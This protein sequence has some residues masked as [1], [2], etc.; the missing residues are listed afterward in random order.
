MNTRNEITSS[1]DLIEQ[2]KEARVYSVGGLA[3]SGAIPIHQ[4][5]M[6]DGTPGTTIVDTGSGTTLNA[7]T[8]SG[9]SSVAGIT[10][11]GSDLAVDFTGSSSKADT[12]TGSGEFQ[13]NSLFSVAVWVNADNLSA[14]QYVFALGTGSTHTSHM[15][16]ET[17]GTVKF[18]IVDDG[19]PTQ[20]QAVTGT[21]EITASTWHLIVGT[22]D[23]QTV[24]VAVD[25]GTRATNDSGSTRNLRNENPFVRFGAT[26][27]DAG[28][29]NLNGQLDATYFF[30]YA[31]TEAD[32]DL[33]Y[34]SGSPT[35]EDLS[36]TPPSNNDV[37]F[38]SSG[39]LSS[40]DASAEA[41]SEVIGFYESTND[42]VVTKRG[43][44]I[45]GFNAQT[46]ITMATDDTAYLSATEAG[47]I[48]NVAP[49]TS[50]HAV[51]KLG[52]MEDA[53]TLILDIK[54]EYIN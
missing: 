3:L 30:D 4:W 52:K 42:S 50:G 27:N 53:S 17:D 31:L 43:A 5:L 35:E 6:N 18:N 40:A 36:V 7:T 19:G 11:F 20:F 46:A 22:W 21:G 29:N 24:T 15:Y 28:T 26:G 12:G 1:T 44:E 41:S 39:K 10:G 54:F 16:F 47:K 37:V 49:T 32:E 48:T 38:L 33:L 23:G 13:T 25:G 8:N 9:V 51:V 14:T 34:A 2:P 45:T